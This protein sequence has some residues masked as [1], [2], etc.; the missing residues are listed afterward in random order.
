MLKTILVG[1]MLVLTAS[2]GMVAWLSLRPPAPIALA[3]TPAPPPPARTTILVVSRSM[4]AGRL[5][6]PEDIDTVEVPGAAVPDGARPDSTASRSELISAMVRHAMLAQQ[7]LLPGDVLRPTDGGFL[8]AVLAPHHRAV[9]VAVDAVSGTAGLIWPGDRVD[10]ILTQVL[11]EQTLPAGRRTFGETVLQD[12]RVIAVDQQLARGAT[13]DVTTQGNR[14][15]TLEVLPKEAERVAVAV[16]LGRVA[17]TV[18]AADV[19]QPAD[20]GGLT[21]QPR[22]SLIREIAHRPALPTVTAPADPSP[23]TWGQDVSPALAQHQGLGAGA[24]VR[25]FQGPANDKEFKFE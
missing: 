4:Q 20:P 21:P 3:E 11:D 2:F 13:P 14:T 16:R 23:T 17:L 8:A 5:I 7:P 6:K 1:M 10:L 22:M 19:S 24:T 9:S 18:R 25:V 12:L 15:V